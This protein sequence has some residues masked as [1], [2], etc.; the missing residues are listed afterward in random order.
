[1]S[2]L[3]YESPLPIYALDWAKTPGAG[4]SSHL[5]RS[6]FRLALGTF[7]EDFRNRVQIIG[8]PD[9]SP[10]Q[11][12]IPDDPYASSTPSNAPE[13]KS[14]FVVLAD[15]LHGYPITKI[16]WEP[17]SAFREPWKDVSSELLTSTGDALRIWEFTEHE[18]KQMSSYVGRSTTASIGKVQQKV[19][20]SSTK[21]PNPI[22]APLTSFSWN[23]ISPHLVVTSSID[24]TCTVW[25]LS[26]SNAVTQLIAHDREVYDVAWI[27]GSV[28]SFVSVG[29]D[30]SLRAFDLRS[31]DHSTILYETPA[32]PVAKPPTTPG[33]PSQTPN[34][35]MT[36]GP[37]QPLLRIAFNPLDANFLST[38]HA[39]SPDVQILD[40][41]SPGRP[42]VEMRAHLANVNAVGWSAI[43][44]GLIASASD[45]CQLLIWDLSSTG[46]LPSRPTPSSRSP[47]PESSQ[48]VP[49]RSVTDPA[50]AFF[51][52]SEIN[53]MVW[54]P[55]LVGLDAAGRPYTGKGGTQT[56]WIAC[57]YGR[58]VRAIRV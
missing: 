3:N 1:M 37:T 40:M 15:A 14:D 52:P 13:G 9:E 19:A 55:P 43:E 39:E 58:S 46:V 47:H 17:S 21:N 41:R 31:L 34:A 38:F 2:I 27:P 30:G 29:A 11:E 32:K 49:T 57:A 23:T 7:S 53:N 36:R 5:P 56:E 4:P 16:G 10:L 6:N 28:D 50:L 45:D 20:L 48:N 18:G 24:T 12:I 8:L 54:S 33:R 51:S 42:V 22:T 25:D 35:P 26:A 44:N